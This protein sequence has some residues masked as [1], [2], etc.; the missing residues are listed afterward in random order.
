MRSKP[1]NTSRCGSCERS[2]DNEWCA[3]PKPEPLNLTGENPCAAIAELSGQLNPLSN[4]RTGSE[5]FIYDLISMY[6][7]TYD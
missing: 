5:E 7:G 4:R 1:K 3:V 2:C 6:G